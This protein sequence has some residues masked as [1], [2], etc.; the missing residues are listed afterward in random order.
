MLLNYA[1]AA[2][3][4]VNISQITLAGT[5]MNLPEFLEYDPDGDI[6]LRGHRLGLFHVI[7]YY[8]EGHSPEMLAC[9]YPTLSLALIHKVIAFYLENQSAVDA[10][11]A[12]YR[13]TLEQ[14]REANPRRLNIEQLRQRLAATHQSEIGS[15]VAGV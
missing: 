4:N 8:Q 10:Y 2:I 3:M 13:Q 7:H 15:G 9:R 6:N 11:I 12:E 14:E 1:F 5:K